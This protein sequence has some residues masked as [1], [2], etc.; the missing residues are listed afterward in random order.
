MV[1]GKVTLVEHDTYKVHVYDP[2]KQHK[3]YMPAWECKGKVNKNHKTCPK[4][5]APEIMD[6]KHSDLE[7]ITKLTASY[8]I[9]K[10]AWTAMKAK[11]VVL[12]LEYTEDATAC[13]GDRKTD[14]DETQGVV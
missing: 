12:P 5:Y 9:P 8:K 2:S 3:C 4:A 1:P 11:G 7:M 6:V 13:N 10:Q 14:Q